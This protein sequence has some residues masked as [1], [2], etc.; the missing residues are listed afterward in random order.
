MLGTG[1]S[2]VNLA[3]E[4]ERYADWAANVSTLYER[5]ARDI[6]DD[7]AL[8]DVAGEARYG[9]PAP[10][11]LLGAV[12]FLLL[13]SDRGGDQD[14]C[15]NGECIEHPL[16]DFYPTCSDDSSEPPD[17]D[18]FACFRAFCL[19]NERTIRE[20]VATRRV[21]TNEVGRS[22]VLL[23]AFEYVTRATDDSP[24]ALVEIG[25]SAG[26]NLYWDHYRY[27]YE[28]DGIY[29]YRDS[30]VRIESAIRGERDPPL[31]A[32]LPN[33]A[34]RVGID[35]NPL[36]ATDPDDARWLRALVI[37]DQHERHERLAS[38][39]DVL[40]GNPPDIVAGNALDVLPDVLDGLPEHATPCVY[41]T[42]TLYQLD[43]DD[44]LELQELLA[45][46]SDRGPIHWLSTDPFAD[47]DRPVCQHVIFENGTTEETRL[48]EHEAY[49][50][51]LRWI[52]EG[53]NE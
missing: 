21:Q 28:G 17:G 35:L 1:G 7:R 15:G 9:Q 8:L 48:T 31:P 24:L 37:P 23:P 29:G 4:F 25:A 41:S 16:A 18:P 6:A 47:R 5:L 50:K 26:L 11:L 34:S 36:D 27:E 32:S 19:A 3:G 45:E 53:S 40:R 46:S 30:P 42:L 52:D 39:I 12:H 38:A 22:A 43:E 51:W 20:I 49:G 10:Q 13:G 2:T 14:G 33:V 44:V